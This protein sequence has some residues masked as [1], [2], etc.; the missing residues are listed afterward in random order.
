MQVDKLRDRVVKLEDLTRGLKDAPQVI[1]LTAPGID[2]EARQ[3]SCGLMR[4]NDETEQHFLE[5]AM[6]VADKERRIVTVFA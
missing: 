2:N 3:S 4:G 5:R 1:H 6:E